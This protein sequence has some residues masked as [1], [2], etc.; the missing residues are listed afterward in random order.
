MNILCVQ[1][2]QSN[3][4]QSEIGPVPLQTQFV[5]SALKSIITKSF[6]RGD[7]YHS[8][9]A[10]SPFDFSHSTKQKVWNPPVQRLEKRSNSELLQKTLGLN[11]WQT[12]NFQQAVIFLLKGVSPAF[13][14]DTREHVW[15]PIAW[16]QTVT[17]N[18]RSLRRAP[19]CGYFFRQVSLRMLHTWWRKPKQRKPHIISR[20][21]TGP[22]KWKIHL[23]CQRVC[24]VLFFWTLTCSSAH[25]LSLSKERPLPKQAGWVHLKN[26]SNGIKLLFLLCQPV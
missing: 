17:Q 10:V 18:F 4:F 7:F 23:A 1:R 11:I 24:S 2:W 5:F 3:W 8:T 21:E 15:L 20:Q 14:S 12:T 13:S 25:V 26:S 19:L 6:N 22:H 9:Q 16:L